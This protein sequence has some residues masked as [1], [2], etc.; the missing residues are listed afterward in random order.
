MN[1]KKPTMNDVAKLAGVG[2]GTVSN[3]INGY[4]IQDQNKVKIEAAIKELNYIPNLQ[5]RE[6]K[7]SK[8]SSVVFIVPN[9]WTP[10]FSE[11][12]FK[13]QVNLAKHG[14]RMILAN[15]HKNPEEEKE[16]L[17]MATLNQVAGVITMSYSDIYNM[18][19]F[20]KQINMVSIERY[21]SKEIP[22]ISSDNYGGGELAAKKLIDYGAHRFLILR[23]ADNHKNAT[24]ERQQG[25]LDFINKKKMPVDTFQATLSPSF[26]Y[27]F[28]NYLQ[29]HYQNNEIP[30]DGIFAVTDEY[31]QIAQEALN[32]INPHILD[33]VHIIGFDGARPSHRSPRLVDSIRQPVE[34]ICKTSV[35]VLDK[36]INGQPIEDNFKKVLPVSFVKKDKLF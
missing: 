10:F 22:L 9:S 26:R 3:Y 15:S 4:K 31:A 27:E 21:V 25:F 23:R 18:M 30:F 32:V 29:T 28:F 36:M 1:E 33:K 6:L 13:M 7:T 35:E 17:K 16:I 12:V 19:N 20:S 8:N 5:A 11:L 14:Y 24:D 34:E 2:R